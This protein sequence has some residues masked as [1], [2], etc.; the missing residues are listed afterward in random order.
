MAAK[1]FVERWKAL[2]DQGVSDQPPLNELC[3]VNTQDRD[4]T[5]LRDG[6]KIKV[7]KCEV[8]NN[9]YKQGK[10]ADKVRPVGVKIVHYKSKL[11]HLY[12]LGK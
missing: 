5:V 7:F 6:V 2:S 3:K 11:R 10:Q 12:P 9:F 1:E 4:N 8:Y